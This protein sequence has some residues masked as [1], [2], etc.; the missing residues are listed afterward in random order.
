MGRQNA[1]SHCSQVSGDT[2]PSANRKSKLS[3]PATPVAKRT[4]SVIEN[5][6]QIA[7]RRFSRVIHRLDQGNVGLFVCV[8]FMTL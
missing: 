8:A 5:Q 7:H 1:L 6:P 2:L 4:L 3:P